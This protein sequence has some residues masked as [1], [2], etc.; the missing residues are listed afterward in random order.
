M[1]QCPT[2]WFCDHGDELPYSTINILVVWVSG[3]P[4]SQ[5]MYVFKEIH[6]DH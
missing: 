5:N 6:M 3:F 4:F 2:A 1:W